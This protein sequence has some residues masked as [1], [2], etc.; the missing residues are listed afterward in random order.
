[1]DNELRI[2][3]REVAAEVTF[4]YAPDRQRHCIFFLSFYSPQHRGEESLAEYL[5]AKDSFLPLRDKE[6]GEFFIVHVDQIVCVREAVTVAAAEEKPLR[7]VLQTGAGLPLRVSEP[8]YAPRSRPID[9]LNEPARFM[10]FVDDGDRRLFVNKRYIM[11]VEG[12]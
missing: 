2:P 6:N 10:A 4:F 7:L 12:I 8:H 1:M 11:R 9:M 5:N 3:K